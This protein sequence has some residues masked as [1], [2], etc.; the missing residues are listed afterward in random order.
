MTRKSKPPIAIY[1][2]L[3]DAT[4]CRIVEIL[5][6]GPIPVHKLADAFSIS[7]P[8]ISRHLRVLKT[9]GLVAEVKKGR[10]NLYAFRPAKLTAASAWL[11]AI[12]DRTVAEIEFASTEEPAPVVAAEPITVRTREPNPLQQ[13]AP[14][15]VV[16]EPAI[17]VSQAIVAA[18]VELA[19]G[20]EP[21]VQPARSP[22]PPRPP[23]IEAPIDQMGF[24]F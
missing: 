10:E 8:A 17:V 19:S 2:A 23:K 18:E 21:E 3:A 22:R 1:S 24:D 7:R 5:L 13:P 4:R 6:A 12:A 11:A 20:G 16:E 9:A 15:P 14:A